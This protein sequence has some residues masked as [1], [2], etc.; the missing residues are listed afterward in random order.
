MSLML[1]NLTLRGLYFRIFGG[2]LFTH[3]ILGRA[4][5]QTESCGGN[6]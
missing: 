5:A 3:E 1:S 6:G 2:H 4:A